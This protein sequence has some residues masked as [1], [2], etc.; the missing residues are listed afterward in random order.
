[1]NFLILKKQSCWRVREGP[2]ATTLARV[3]EINHRAQRLATAFSLS[4]SCCFSSSIFSPFFFLQRHSE[5]LPT[6]D[7]LEHKAKLKSGELV[8]FPFGLCCPPSFIKLIRTSF[9]PSFRGFNRRFST[10]LRGLLSENW[11]IE[12]FSL[13]RY[14]SNPFQSLLY[15]AH[16]YPKN[17][18]YILFQINWKRTERKSWTDKNWIK[19]PGTFFV[20]HPHESCNN[21][22]F[23]SE[24]NIFPSPTSN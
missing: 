16:T 18:F 22:S 15:L 9:R 10:L 8:L 1:M 3:L 14:F 21:F 17:F 11:C 23:A 4:C 5:N 20:F 13:S 7:C 19:I 12:Y 24:C 2:P 6:P